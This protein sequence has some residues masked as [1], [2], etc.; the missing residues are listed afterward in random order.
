MKINK[1]GK[2]G[3]I[4]EVIALVIIIIFVLFS[5]PVPTILIWFFATGLVISLSGTLLDLYKR[6]RAK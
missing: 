4:I 1:G 6:N 5:K 2:V 3:L